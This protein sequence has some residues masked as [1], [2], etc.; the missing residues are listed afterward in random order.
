VDTVPLKGNPLKNLC[1]TLNGTNVMGL[2]RGARVFSDGDTNILWSQR[3]TVRSQRG[4]RGRRPGASVRPI[5]D[6]FYTWTV[7]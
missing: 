6:N 7:S 5:A 4:R 3:G 2:P 1:R